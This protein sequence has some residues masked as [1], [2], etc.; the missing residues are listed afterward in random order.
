MR[1]F[2]EALKSL[3]S[4]KEF[5]SWRKSNKNDYLS[6][7]FYVLEDDDCNWKIG[8]YNK[9]NDKI[10]TFNV[11]DCVNIEPSEDIFK[12]EETNVEPLDSKKVKLDLAEAVTI[13]NELQ[14]EEYESENPTKII[15]ILQNTEGGNI[16]NITFLTKNFNTLNFKI[17]SDTGRV[18]DKQITNLM[19]FR[20][21]DNEQEPNQQLEQQG[22]EEDFEE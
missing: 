14:Q 17:K 15:A 9:K 2:K 21:K 5:K 13:A 19:E 20:Q 10:T 11:G 16:W 8:Y 4:S 7:G 6:Y 1:Q 12:K 22:E 18:I 3:E